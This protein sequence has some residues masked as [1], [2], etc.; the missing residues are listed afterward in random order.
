MWNLRRTKSKK[1][2]REGFRR[3]VNTYYGGMNRR[4]IAED[5]AKTTARWLVVTVL[6]YVYWLVML[7]LA[8]IFLLNVW[9]VE[10]A[11]LFLYAGI[12][13]AVTSV[14]YALMLVHRKFYY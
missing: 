5:V 6:S 13:C 14:V 1:L 2:P 11:S 3:R 7:L 9:R 10:L 12:L 8:S 4:Q